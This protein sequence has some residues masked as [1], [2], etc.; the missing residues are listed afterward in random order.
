MFSFLEVRGLLFCPRVGFPGA[1]VIEITVALKGIPCETP[2]C[3]H[4]IPTKT[5]QN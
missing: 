2:M 4:L 3:E 1:T 5:V